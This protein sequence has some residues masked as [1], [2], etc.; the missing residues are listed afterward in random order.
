MHTKD[1]IKSFLDRG[2]LLPPNILSKLE[3]PKFVRQLEAAM[4]GAANQA[5]MLASP[6]PESPEPSVGVVFSYEALPKKHEVQDFVQHFGNR[7]AQ[8]K[9]ILMQRA[10]LQHLTSISKILGRKDKESVAFI[11]M[12]REKETNKNG[13]V[14][15]TVEDPT[16]EI[17]VL[18][19]KHSPEAFRQAQSVVHDQA[20]GVLGSNG[21]NIVFA[22]SILLP[23]VPLLKNAKSCPDDAYALFLS[24]L[25]VGSRLF[26]ADEFHRFLEWINARSGS[27]AQ[28]EVAKKVRYIFISGD[29]VDGVGIFPGQEDELEIQDIADQYE[30]CY[31]LLSQIPSRI[32]LIICPGNHDAI[33]LA[34]P[35]SA[36]YKDLAAPLWDLPN[37]LLLSNPSMVTIHKTAAFPGFDVLLYHGYSYDYYVANVEKIRNAG[38]YNR[39]DEIMKYLLQARHLAPSHRSNLYTPRPYS[40]PLVISRVPDIFVSGHIHKTQVGMYRGVTLICASAWQAKTPYQE[41]MGHSPEPCRAPLIN[42]KT[43]EVKIL[44][45]IQ[46]G[47]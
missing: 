15:L 40:D 21:Q 25:H 37:A 20:I 27:D 16:G 2:V 38:G 3:D 17:K 31:R 1:I 13:G 42:L 22:K 28:K 14:V 8:L 7:Y 26:H 12:I 36:F 43:R 29:L 46:D 9:S 34:E 5:Q 32:K 30:E 47:T 35:Q 6:P 10:E 45:F 24:D 23:D 19:T 41:K 39:C 33:Q 18:A 4:P 11:G 44:K